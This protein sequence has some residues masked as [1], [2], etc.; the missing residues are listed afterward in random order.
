MNG[1][2]QFQITAKDQETADQF[3]LDIE[4]L[5][6]TVEDWPSD[7]NEDVYVYHGFGYTDKDESELKVLCDKIGVE[8]AHVE[9]TDAETVKILGIGE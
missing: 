3:G 5:D 2:N 7:E 1:L 9:F 4:A 6:Y 8:L